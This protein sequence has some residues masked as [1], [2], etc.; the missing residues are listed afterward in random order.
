MTTLNRLTEE[1]LRPT[2]KWFHSAHQLEGHL[3]K[4]WSNHYQVP[5]ANLSFYDLVYVLT[6]NGQPLLTYE[7]PLDDKI[8]YAFT[9]RS[10]ISRYQSPRELS[11][12]ADESIPNNMGQFKI[13]SFMLGDLVKSIYNSKQPQMIKINPAKVIGPEQKELTLCDEVLFAPTLDDLTK[14]WMMTPPEDARA[15]LAIHPQDQERYG[16]EIIFHLLSNRSLP[17]EP[18]ERQITLSNKIKDLAFTIPRVPI[19]MGSASIYCVILNLDNA[20]EETAFIRNYKSFDN[21]S[22]VIFVTS[23]FE[24]LTGDLESISYS[25]ESIDTIFTPLIQWQKRKR[26]L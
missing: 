16:I 25:G 18:E 21:H 23:N 20:M 19:Q 10:L 17:E 11:S 3:L 2:S 5:F 14:K 22:D 24:I 9:S 4:Y 1:T 6:D 12:I 13:K 8:C 15:L 26:I 7:A